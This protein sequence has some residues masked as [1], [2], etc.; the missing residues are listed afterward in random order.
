[1]SKR[2]GGG[3]GSLLAKKSKEDKRSATTAAAR[4]TQ[5]SRNLYLSRPVM[6]EQALMNFLGKVRSTALQHVPKGQSL[7]VREVS[8]FCSPQK[9]VLALVF[10]QMQNENALLLNKSSSS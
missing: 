10:L 4:P 5:Q 8:L 3:L 6:P 2:P 9:F 7:P 1:M